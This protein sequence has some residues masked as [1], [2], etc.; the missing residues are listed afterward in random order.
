MLEKSPFRPETSIIGDTT[1]EFRLLSCFLFVLVKN[2][3]Q[4]VYSRQ[5][6]QTHQ[7]SLV[8]KTFHFVK[9]KQTF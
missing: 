5:H 9:V 1:S 2:I 7:S 4:S 6:S 8:L 3:L